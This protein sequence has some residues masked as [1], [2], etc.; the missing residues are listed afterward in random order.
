VPQGSV[1]GPLLFILHFNDITDGLKSILETFADESKLYSIMET[2][3]DIEILP[4]DF[5]F[6]SN[7]SKNF[8]YLSST[9]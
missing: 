3:R 1:L 9:L 8:G 7:W 6:I 2:R 5:N 4:E